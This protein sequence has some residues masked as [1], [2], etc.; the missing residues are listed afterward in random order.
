MSFFLPNRL[1]CFLCQQKIEARPQAAQL[2]LVDD[3]E[4]GEVAQHGGSWVH[5]ACWQ[6]SDVRERWAAAA[7]RRLGGESSLAAGGVVCRIFDDEVLLD[8][9]WQAL[10]LNL[11]RDCVEVLLAAN[12]RGGEVYVHSSKWTFTP[13]GEVLDVSAEINGVVFE[14][15]EH[16]AGRW[17]AA[18]ALVRDAPP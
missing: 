9:P 11:P 5:R 15:L 1:T 16:P 10:S 6:R 3:A 17:S 2:Q 18:L 8:D 13:R 4:L 14:V 7:L 12:E